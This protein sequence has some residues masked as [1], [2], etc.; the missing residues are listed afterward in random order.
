MKIT[1]DKRL[2]TID[3][4][5]RTKA[6]AKEFKEIYTDGDLLRMFR[7]AVDGWQYGYSD[8]IIR[9]NLEAFPGGTME[10][11]ENHYSVEI[12]LEGF[13][14]FTKIHFYISQSGDI[15]TRYI[16]DGDKWMKMWQVEEYKLA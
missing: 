9:C 11:D 14:L 6:Q 8:E 10:T 3:K 15:D 5:E 1:I 12:L 7:D 2:T 16:L 4:A 13:R